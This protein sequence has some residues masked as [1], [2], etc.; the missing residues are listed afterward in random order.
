MKRKNN[1]RNKKV[2]CCAKFFVASA[3]PKVRVN[4][5]VICKRQDLEN[6]FWKST[7][8]YRKITVSSAIH[9][10]RRDS[11]IPLR[12]ADIAA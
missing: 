12:F 1:K 8:I 11:L 10:H 4:L 9:L 3:S 6:F 7:K 2:F 5:E